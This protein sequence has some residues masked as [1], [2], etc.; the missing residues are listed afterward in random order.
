[1]ET[2]DISNIT[3]NTAQTGGTVGANSG[4]AVTA[5]GVCW[6]TKQNPTLSDSKTNNG[7]GIGSF[8]CK[9]EGLQ[10]NTTYYLRAYA[11]NSNGTAYGEQKTF[12]TALVVVDIDGNE[13]NTVKIGN[14]TSYNFV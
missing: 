11:T 13:Y 10:T 4:P 9:I 5:F 14:Q 2:S 7:T 3:K 8:S 6:S 12:T 1:M